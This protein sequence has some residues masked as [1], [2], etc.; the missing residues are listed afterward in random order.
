MNDDSAFIRAIV[1]RPDDDTVRLVYA[2]WLEERGD[3]RG[4]FLRLE[5]ALARSRDARQISAGQTRL[6]ALRKE[7]APDWLAQMSRSK[8]EL[9]ESQFAFQCPKQWDK[10]RPTD[11]PGVRFCDAC[12]E[13]VYYSHTIEEARQHA[14][15]FR[16]VAVDAGVERKEGD[17]ERPLVL[18][19]LFVPERVTHRV[20]ER[21]TQVRP[22][23][24]TRTRRQQ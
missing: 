15:R 18:G 23:R 8:I 22:S 24:Q 10:L 7:I 4:E 3:P 19:R 9:C 21:P 16:C 17:L 14:W 2:D 6:Q 11:E 20:P 12:S 1:A 13:N 5:A